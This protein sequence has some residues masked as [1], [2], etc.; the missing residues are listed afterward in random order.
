MGL[1][2]LI[3]R[4]TV[5]SIL[6]VSL[7]GT[8]QAAPIPVFGTG[9]DA[10]GTPL[11][12]G[13]ADPHYTVD[14]AG[15]AAAEVR[16]GIAGTYF[17]NDASSQWIW[18]NANGTPVGGSPP[19]GLIRTFTT[20]FD[21]TGLEPTSAVLSG[22][23]GT[24]NQGLEILLNGVDTGIAPLLGVIVANFSS[25][26]PFSISSGFLPGLNTLQFVIEDN[27][28]QAAFRAELSGTAAVVP[29]PA[30]LPLFMAAL[31]L[32]GLLGWRRESGATV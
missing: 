30:A 18:E 24:D 26:T 16:T 19:G 6:I 14:E 17:G 9:L 21:L 8:A 3:K 5:S 20:T 32:L 13:A 11:A 1:R 7:V 31:A 25:L 4:A 15:D 10:S 23:W 27:G 12:L 28:G 2:K 22:A 29:V